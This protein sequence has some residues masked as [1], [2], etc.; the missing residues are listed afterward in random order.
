MPPFVSTECPHCQKRNRFDLAEL[1]KTDTMVMKNIL[2]HV[3]SDD[4]EE[5]SVTC[6]HCGRKFKLTMRGGKDG[7]EK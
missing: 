5:F 1:N 6:Q 2:L 3:V 7:E 4:D